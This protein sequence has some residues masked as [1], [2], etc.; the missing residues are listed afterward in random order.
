[1]KSG[2]K[3]LVL[4]AG[5]LAVLAIAGGAG[6][7][8]WL[9]KKLSREAIVS[10][11]ENSW[12]CR[13]EIDNVSLL[14]MASPARLEVTGCRIA[15]RDEESAKPL[16]LRAPLD[17]GKADVSCK[18][19]VLEVR[20]QDLLTGTLNVRQLVLS[21]LAVREDVSKEGVSSL[22]V[23]FSKPGRET[24]EEAPV[25]VAATTKS[26]TPEL[27]SSASAPAASTA[28]AGEATS[29]ASAAATA[30]APE[31][32]PAE[33]KKH[34]RRGFEAK[35]LG[36]SILVERASLEHVEFHRIDHKSTTKT[37]VSDL[38]F[39]IGDI[40]VNPD[41]LAGHNSFKL[42]LDGRLKQRGRIGPK[43]NR[44]EVTM[45]EIDFEGGGTV[46]PFDATT[47]RWQP[48]SDLRLTV[49]K[50]SVFGGFMKVGETGVKELE[51]MAQYG[52]DI[53][54]LPMG[55]PLIEN[56]DIHIIPRQ[57][58]SMFAER[59]RFVLA[60]FELSLEKGSWLNPSD[61]DHNFQLRITCGPALQARLST[62]VVNNAGKDL[63]ETL[64]KALKDEKGRI[65]FDAKSSGRLS[66]LK[67]E[68]DTKRFLNRL[69][70]GALEGV[71]KSK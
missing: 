23:L 27:V 50:N 21:D 66:K 31:R 58:R 37:D 62:A 34:Q 40:D 52:I 7:R 38:N 65:Y 19:S 24:K 64:L 9:E 57:D 17:P 63:G 15:P 13:A 45:A 70:E 30:T 18:R 51:K 55:G 49:K 43:E 60:D 4:A 16:A 3:K 59:A 14:L 32:A 39:T 10:E 53:S 6:L 56:A 67:P 28:G 33:K 71:I 12:N 20:L 2:V 22:G 44:R 25:V 5:T 1:M 41:D 47:G 46:N 36:L 61:D 26:V 48:A 68:F 11:M 54:D 8:W 35:Q 29:P 42:A 69:L